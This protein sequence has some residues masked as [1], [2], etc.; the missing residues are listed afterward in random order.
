M[1]A[2]GR[3]LVHVPPQEVIGQ[4]P[5]NYKKN[6][7]KVGGGGWGHQHG[8]MEAWRR[9]G[10]RCALRRAARAVGMRRPN[11]LHG[12][13]PLCTHTHARTA[14]PSPPP[15]QTVCQFWL[16]GMC[17]KGDQCGFLHQFDVDKMPICRNLLKY[18][19]CKELDCPYKHNTGGA[20]CAAPCRTC[21]ALRHASG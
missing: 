21:C 8:G 18:G 10:W 11:L 4:Q 13:P 19:E 3:E 2:Q 5:G 1:R 15:L 9:H 6:Y 17:M 16:K 12:R 14:E 20:A 7:K